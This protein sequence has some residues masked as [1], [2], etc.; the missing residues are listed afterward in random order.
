MRFS[1]I[2]ATV[3]RT[4][5]VERFL[6]SLDSQTHRDFEL[7]V[8]DQNDDDRL[9]PLLRL[10][11]GRFPIK[12]LSSERGLSRAR[13]VG[14]RHVEGVIVAF[15]DDDC[16]YP[17]DLLTRVAH[18]LRSH[19]EYDG[20]TGK[21]ISLDD[22]TPVWRFADS[23]AVINKKNVWRC[24]TSFSIFLRRHVVDK[25]GEFDVKLGVGA[26]TKWGSAEEMEYLCRCI[27]VHAAIYYDPD[28][29]VLHPKPTLAYDAKTVSRG[30]LYGRGMGRV[31]SMHKLPY[32]FVANIFIRPLGGTMLSLLSGRFMK[33]RYHWAVFRGRFRGWYGDTENNH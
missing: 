23:P 4:G 31:M 17:S 5:E 21:A 14:L 10:Y 20:L 1:L 3:D 24:G 27:D 9:V 2:L 15:P 22:N 25:V 33:A 18:Y 28:L 8:V 12:H 32:L 30:Y 11:E 16:V 26:G 29:K 19:P 13:N 6:Q 7:I